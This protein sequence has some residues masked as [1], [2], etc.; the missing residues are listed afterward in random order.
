MLFSHVT[1]VP[2]CRALSHLHPARFR[3]PTAAAWDLPHRASRR[4]PVASHFYTCQHTIYRL[5][6]HLPAYLPPAAVPL[7]TMRASAATSSY[8]CCTRRFTFTTC[9]ISPGQRTRTPLS[10][11]PDCRTF[12]IPRINTRSYAPTTRMT[13][14]SGL[15]C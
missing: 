3:A 4:L 5:I 13:L 7:R 6:F 14:F 9:G 15:R 10:C 11:L 1:T 12:H 8:S 2:C